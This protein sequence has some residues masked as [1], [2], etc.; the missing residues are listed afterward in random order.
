MVGS[1]DLL[2]KYVASTT[3]NHVEANSVFSREKLIVSNIC[4]FLAKNERFSIKNA[5]FLLNIPFSLNKTSLVLNK[6]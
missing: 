4:L 5:C 2:C 1:D 6:S 3:D